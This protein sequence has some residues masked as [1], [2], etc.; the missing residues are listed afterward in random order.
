VRIEL[1]HVPDCPNLAIAR[2]HI[3]AA[4]A[5]AHVAASLPE[6]EVGSLDAAVAAGMHGS[7]TILVDGVDPF[8]AIGTEPTISCRLYRTDDGIQGAPSVE[9]LVDAI[10]VRRIAATVAATG[11]VTPLV[12]VPDWR[13]GADHR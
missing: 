8:A 12:G 4:L 1:L 13:T 9:Q 11:P 7:P 10:S 2:E 6:I 5:S 3:R